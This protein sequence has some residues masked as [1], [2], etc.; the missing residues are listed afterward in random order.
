MNSKATFFSNLVILAAGVLLCYEHARVDIS[1]TIIIVTGIALIVPGLINLVLLLAHRSD[2]HAPTAT[3]RIAGWI[4]SVAAIA[5]GGIMVTMPD[6]FTP[7][8]VYLFGGVMI[9]ASLML[10]FLI[11]RAVKRLSI[12]A[13][14]M[15][16]PILVLIAGVVMVCMGQERFSENITTL[17]VGISMIVYSFSWYMTSILIAA[18][19]HRERKLARKAQEEALKQ[20][21]A[22]PEQT[23]EPEDPTS[24]KTPEAE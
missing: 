20:S 19:N 4:S 5:L 15:A 13:W 6:R 16:G 9:V 11:L 17:I 12:A 23:K 18:H 3:M 1:R 22:T 7:V 24:E 2:T 8:L 21:E 10:I 14:P